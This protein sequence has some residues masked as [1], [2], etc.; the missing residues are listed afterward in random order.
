MIQ[1]VLTLPGGGQDLVRRLV[2]DTGA[3][4]GQSVFQLILDGKD[5]RQCG[6]VPMGHVRLGGAYSGSFP[7]YL[8]GVRIPQLHFDEPVPVV[9]VSKV[10]QGF[11]GIAG[12]RFLDRFNYGNFGKTDSFAL[13]L[14][15]VP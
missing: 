4:T 10:P 5:C 3:G 13:D 7:L 12:F 8:V 15:T 9:G 11:D 1:I 2:A 6:G 14:I